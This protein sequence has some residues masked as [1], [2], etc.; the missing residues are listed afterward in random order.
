M[1]AFKSQL[2]HA[3]DSGGRLTQVVVP[4]SCRRLPWAF[5]QITV[6]AREMT[7]DSIR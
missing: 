5:S 2:T 1:L 7:S 6:V 3:Y 4:G